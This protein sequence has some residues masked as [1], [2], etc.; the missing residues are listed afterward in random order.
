MPT[1]RVPVRRYDASAPTSAW[2]TWASPTLSA[3]KV[4]YLTA[5]NTLKVTESPEHWL[6]VP[7]SH[8]KRPLPPHS[9]TYHLSPL[10]SS[11]TYSPTFLTYLTL[12]RHQRGHILA[13][14]TLA[15][16][17]SSDTSAPLL[18]F[19]SLP[20]E[21]S[22]FFPV[23]PKLKGD[24]ELFTTRG[25]GC[26]SPW[27]AWRGA[28][29][30]FAVFAFANHSEGRLKHLVEVVSHREARGGALHHCLVWFR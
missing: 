29:P 14:F 23:S 22:A 27:G 30:L 20:V 10:S 9:R 4:A 6:P 26:E 1:V 2:L 16:F 12:C 19:W 3:P 11:T 17:A 15:T 8:Y 28:S 5:L 25:R 13:S 18:V 24:I 21:V 7:S